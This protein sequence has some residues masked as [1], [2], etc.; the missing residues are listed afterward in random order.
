MFNTTF[1]KK[2]IFFQS[3]LCENILRFNPELKAMHNNKK[4]MF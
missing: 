4:E 2:I 1:C 3:G